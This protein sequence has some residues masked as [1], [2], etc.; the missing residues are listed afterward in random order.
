MLLIFTHDPAVTILYINR[1]PLFREY[2]K[3]RST[4]NVAGLRK[5]ASA[6]M[7]RGILLIYLCASIA[8]IRMGRNRND[9][10]DKVTGVLKDTPM[11]NYAKARF[12]A[13][14]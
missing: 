7:D 9:I 1:L 12:A 11:L 3:C 5:V 8:A 4:K 14:E 10:V 2:V 6:A 13:M